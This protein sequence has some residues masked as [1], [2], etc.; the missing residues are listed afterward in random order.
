LRQSS[1]LQALHA[2]KDPLQSERVRTSMMLSARI[3]S[4]LKEKGWSKGQLA[5]A[6]KKNPSIISRWL[7]GTHN[8]TSDTLSD[9]QK[10][11]GIQLLVRSPEEQKPIINSY[12]V[13]D[14]ELQ[15]KIL[16][17]EMRALVENA[18]HAGGC[19][20]PRMYTTIVNYRSEQ[21]T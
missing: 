21:V 13:S 4:A 10:I 5:I 19:A 12:S 3:A 8:F 15:R 18:A 11:L 20:L 16:D 2:K 1:V 14:P 17:K 9:I 6:L 7:S